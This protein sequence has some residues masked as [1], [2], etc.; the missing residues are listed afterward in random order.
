MKVLSLVTQKGGT[1]KSALTVSL[2]VAAE[3]A[4]E[5]VVI[6][7]LDPQGTSASWYEA[8]TSETPA[9]L[10]H[11]QAGQLS[12]TLPR[13][14]A[15]GFTLAIVDTPGID[16]PSTRGAMREATLALVPVRPSE[17]DVKATMPT[18]RALEAMGRPYAL[19]INQAPTGRQARLTA[20]VSLR[21]STSGE[22]VPAAVA[23]RIDHQYA[24]ALG[25][26]VHEYAP[27]G[28]AAAEVAEVWAWC[29]KKMEAVFD[30]DTQRRG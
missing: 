25:Q 5:R 20:A 23:S 8:R 22:V 30:P 17:A 6:L 26:G 29:R 19:V 15:A 4:G 7:D 14:A 18:V 24:Y 16:S 12:D 13:L 9:V 21:L 10:D 2:A 3:M 1:G 27:D 28:K 11:N